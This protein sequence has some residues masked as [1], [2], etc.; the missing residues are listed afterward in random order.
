LTTDAD[1]FRR[2]R[3][4][5][6]IPKGALRFGQRSSPLTGSP[7]LAVSPAGAILNYLYALLEAEA[8]LACLTVGLDPALGVLHADVR[9]RDSLPLDLMEAVRPNVDRYLHALLTD[10]VFHA[11]DFHENRRGSC[12]LLPP[13]SHELAQTLPAWRRLIAPVA[14]QACKLLVDQRPPRRQVPTPLT[15]TNRRADRARRH[16]RAVAPART[17]MPKPERRCKRCG[18][19]LPHRDRVYCDYCLPHYQADRYQAF[20]AARDRKKQEQRRDGV[21]PSHGG[22]AAT[23]R[24]ASVSRHQ[25]EVHRWNAANERPD[26]SLFDQQIL[27]LIRELPLADLVRATG[28]THGYLSQVRRGLKTPHPRHWPALRRAT[29][30]GDIRDVSVMDRT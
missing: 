14:E 4:G 26:P 23:K 3:T 9:G 16:Q 7:R 28:L 6:F 2:H 30:T 17:R 1:G 13:L 21:D 15:E 24:G 29:P 10:R 19:P 22:D 27:P 12:R 25:H 8:R 11:G 18:G 20:V 5:P